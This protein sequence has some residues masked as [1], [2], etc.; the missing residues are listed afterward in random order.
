MEIAK[1]PIFH[2][3]ELPSLI[4]KD[5]AYTKAAESDQA[6]YDLLLKNTADFVR[7]FVSATEDETWSGIHEEFMNMA[8][9]WFTNQY[10]LGRLDDGFAKEIAEAFYAHYTILQAALPRNIKIKIQSQIIPM[11]SLL[12]GVQS[13]YLYNLIVRECRDKHK[14]VLV[15]PAVDEKNA[16][17]ISDYLERCQLQNLW[18]LE[19]KEIIALLELAKKLHLDPLAEECQNILKRYLTSENVLDSLITAHLKHWLLLKEESVQFCNRLNWGIELFAIDQDHLGFEFLQFNERTWEIFSKLN[20]F[21]TH[22]IVSKNLVIQDRFADAITHCPKLISLDLSGSENL[23]PFL[24][25]V[26]EKVKEL[27][28]AR[29]IWLDDKTFKLIAPLFPQITNLDLTQNTDITYLSWGELKKFPELKSLQV[30]HCHQ[31]GDAELSLILQSCIGLREIN[32]SNCRMITAKGFIELAQTLTRLTFIKAEKTA[33]SDPGLV[34]LANRAHFIETADFSRCFDLTEKG[35]AYFLKYEGN[36]K[37]LVL[38]ETRLS[39]ETIQDLQ[40]F[41]PKVQIQS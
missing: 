1:W 32:L 9:I 28:L 13:N 5:F 41:Y 22:L 36:L 31:I 11:N 40:K 39:E 10:F 33:I 24:D 21:I 12:L 8:L 18:K 26:P 27:V 6:L 37:T 19:K 23:S 35:I 2:L 34:E 15:L 30:A 16:A 17:F 25:Q 3:M 20:W 38:G 14:K 29:C 7:F 4:P